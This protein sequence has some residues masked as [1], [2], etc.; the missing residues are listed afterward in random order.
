MSVRAERNIVRYFN[1]HPRVTVGDNADVQCILKIN[2]SKQTVGRVLNRA[3]MK[4][5]RKRKTPLLKSLYLK[6]RLELAKHLIDKDVVF[7]KQIL[8][9]DE[10]KIEIFGYNCVV[11]F[12][13][14]L[15]N[16]FFL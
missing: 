10:I 15:A 8:W 7:W 12:I 4:A 1:Q 5:Y 16:I 11:L 9:S 2:V 14:N 13:G 3:G 6:A